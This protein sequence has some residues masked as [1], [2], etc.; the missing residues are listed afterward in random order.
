VEGAACSPGV[1]R[2]MPVVGSDTSFDVGREQLQLLA[3]I[4]VTA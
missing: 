4:A 2:M 1:R 3:G